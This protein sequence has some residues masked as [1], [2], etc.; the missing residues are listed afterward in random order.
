MDMRPSN[1]ENIQNEYRRIDE[2]WL[3]AQYRLMICLAFFAFGLELVLS[4]VLNE[5]NLIAIPF[6]TYLWK[7]LFFPTACNALLVFAAAAATY[8]RRLTSTH[9]MYVVSLALTAMAFILYTV[10]SIFPSLF[11][12]FLIPMVLTVLY[13]NL[14]LTSLVSM[15]SIL[16]KAVSDLFLFWDPRRPHIFSNQESAFDFGLSLLLLL[17]FY[18]LCCCLLSLERLKNE[19]SLKLEREREQLWQ[20]SMIDPLTSVGNRQAMREAFFYVEQAPNLDPASLSLA[21]M[22]LDDFKRLNDTYGHVVGD[23]FLQALGKTL[24]SVASDSI[25]PFRFGGD[26]FCLMFYGHSREEI[27]SICQQVQ[28]SLLKKKIHSPCPPLSISIGVA[29]YSS[30]DTL[31]QLFDKADKA[32]YRAKGNKGS[33]CFYHSLGE[34]GC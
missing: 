25:R 3:R 26:E 28:Q 20:K 27:H 18:V 4:F 34:S 23:K 32:L 5:V 30:T 2:M 19:V 6:S 9:K 10:H 7:Y 11:L 1:L 31:S 24:L 17:L 29:Q 21:V 15:L 14:I 33:I 16:G 12:I 22:D 8:S 13:G